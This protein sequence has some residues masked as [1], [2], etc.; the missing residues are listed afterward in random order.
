MRLSYCSN[1]Q[2][3]SCLVWVLFL[4]KEKLKLTVWLGH[5]AGRYGSKIISVFLWVVVH[6]MNY[7]I[8]GF[9]EISLTF[10]S[11]C[12][13]SFQLYKNDN[14]P[15]H[16]VWV[17]RKVKESWSKFNTTKMHLLILHVLQILIFPLNKTECLEN[18]FS[19]KACWLLP[20]LWTN[21]Y[22]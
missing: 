22:H 15:D 7:S 12:L 14:K 11:N 18:V 1:N 13:I 16:Q 19:T 10:S 8:F 21:T 4:S 2:I 9:A 6:N 20:V 5:R 17:N 3:C